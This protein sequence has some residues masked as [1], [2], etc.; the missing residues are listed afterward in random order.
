MDP[1]FRKPVVGLV[2][3]GALAALGPVIGLFATVL[4]LQRAFGAVAAIDPSRKAT[5]LAESISGAMTWTAVGL[6]AG[7]VGMLVV[8]AAVLLLVRA[9]PAGARPAPGPPEP[10][11]GAP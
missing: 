9:A 6:G 3:G 2:A 4:S 11:G 8:L 10:P 5:V 7:V 1:A